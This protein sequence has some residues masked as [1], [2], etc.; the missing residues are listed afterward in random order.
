M[1]NL[2]ICWELSFTWTLILKEINVCL[3]VAKSCCQHLVIP[4][5]SSVP[6]TL[7]LLLLMFT[8]CYLQLF[9]H[10]NH[11]SLNKIK[12]FH[13]CF[14]WWDWVL[15]EK[16]LLFFFV[17]LSLGKYCSFCVSISFSIAM[18]TLPVRHKV[19]QSLSHFMPENWK[20]VHEAT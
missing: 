6:Y 19:I 10:Q 20:I 14:F 8:N 16:S 18:W 2:I 12:T 15:K 9:L 3:F 13:K 1:E 7:V 4:V 5:T 17:F 11:I